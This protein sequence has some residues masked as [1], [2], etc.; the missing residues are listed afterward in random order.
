MS[1]A[2]YWIE[3]TLTLLPALPGFDVV[4]D[5]DLQEHSKINRLS[6]AEGLARLDD[7]H[8]PYVA[9]LAGQPVGYGWVATR[10]ASIGELEL[11]FSL[12]SDARYLWDFATLPDWQGRGLYPRLLQTILEREN[13]NA[14]RFW[15]IH[16]PENLP[17]GAGMNK[18]GFEF[19]GQLSFTAEGRVG[20]AP[21]SDTLERARSGAA[22]LG[23]P[24]I[25]SVLAPCWH[26]G[27]MVAKLP[28]RADIDSCWPPRRMSE[29]VC[30]CAVEVKPSKT[31]AS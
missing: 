29:S 17:S 23:V 11:T 15:I 13:Q 20:L 27:G 12:P 9:R 30:C 28:D 8:L 10:K 5:F 19:V 14:N 4:I 24:L 3:D 25:E 6:Q 16:A 7:G 2:T 22:L 26:C 1:L 31:N 18:A 21:F